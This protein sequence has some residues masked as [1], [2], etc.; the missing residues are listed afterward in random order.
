MTIE[1]IELF[2]GAGGLAL[3]MHQAGFLPLALLERDKDSCNTLRINLDAFGGGTT[4]PR[5]IEDDIRDFDYSDFV[6]RVKFVTGGPPCQPFSLGGKHGGRDDVRDMF[7]EAVRA[8]RELR[9]LGFMFEN[10]RG[11]LRK[12]FAPYFNYILLQL[13]HPEVLADGGGGWQDHLRKLERHHASLTRPDFGYDVVYQQVNAAD[14]GVPQLRHRVVIAGF[15]ND[16]GVRWSFPG[17]AC[18]REALERAKSGDGAYWKEH[19]ISCAG[20]PEYGPFLTGL[21]GLEPCERWR[22]VR[23]AFVGLP[24]PRSGD[25]GGFANHEFRGDARAYKGHSGSIL[26]DPSKALKAGVHGV[27]GG[28]NSVL[29]DD[30]TLRHYTAREAARI[31]TFP[32]TYVFDGSWSESMRQIGNAVPVLLARAIGE[33]VAKILLRPSIMTGT[34]AYETRKPVHD[35]NAGVCHG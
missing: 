19:G 35:A 12:P 27:P 6:D 32:D 5:V 10:V 34:Q 22:T 4:S 17:P 24:D 26:D 25:S 14:Y 7:P 23:D 30:G 9:P 13:S 18:S 2:A 16:L 1:S 11:L 8:V 15:R 20:L 33:S 3:G 28:E 29:L 21:A 31:Q